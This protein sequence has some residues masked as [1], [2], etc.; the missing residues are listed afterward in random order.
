MSEKPAEQVQYGPSP[1]LSRWRARPRVRTRK[2]SR[3]ERRVVLLGARSGG[4]TDLYHGLLGIPIW[5]L[6][7]VLGSVYVGLN[8]I[9]AGLYLLDPHGVTG[10][11]PGDFLDAFFFSVQTLSTVGYGALSPVDAYANLMVTAECFLNLVMLAVTTGVI[12][13]RVSRP[14]ARVLFSKIATVTQFEGRPH[15]MFRAINERSNQILEAEV[16]LSLARQTVTAEGRVWRRF[17]DLEVTRRRTPLFALSWTI[18]H[19]LDESSPLYGASPESLVADQVE[20]IV[21]ISGVDDTF[22][23]RIHARY[24]YGAENIVWDK[25]FE[26][27]LSIEPNGCWVLDYRKFHDVKDAPSTAPH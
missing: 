26:N 1:L 13:A 3:G 19:P 15:L 21:V 8:V 10:V 7:V 23:Q 12:F 16:M 9:F 14:T 25:E 17:Q 11:K 24:A 6:F 20:L 5:G 22:A 18:M 4:V 2:L 27:V